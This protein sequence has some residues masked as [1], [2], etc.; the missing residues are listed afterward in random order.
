MVGLASKWVRLA[1][2]GTNLGPF[3]ISFSI[4]WLAESVSASQNVLKLILKSPIFV[5]FE[6][7]LTPYLATTLTSLLHEYIVD[8]SAG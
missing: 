4:F 2:N 3:K 8:D 6:S 7:N 1:P 5:P